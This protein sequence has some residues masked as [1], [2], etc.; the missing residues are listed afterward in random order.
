[1]ASRTA[2]GS[3]KT[4]FE[5]LLRGVRLQ[6]SIFFRPEFGAPWGVNISGHGTVF[7][8]VAG[9]T[10]WLRIKDVG[11]PIQLATGDFAVVTRGD[12]HVLSGDDPPTPSVDFFELIKRHGSGTNV[13]F[14]EGGQGPITSFVCGGMQFENGANDPLLAVLPPLLHIRGTENAAVPWLRLTVEQVLAELNYGGAG[15]A[16]VV[17]RL[18]DILFIQAVRTHFEDHADTARSGWLAAVRDKQIGRALALLHAH[19]DEPWTVEMLARRLTL[20]RSAFADRFREL[21]G[22]PPLQYLSRLRINAAARRLRSTNDKLS[23]V[24]ADAGY[25]SAAA[26]VRAFKQRVGMT[27]G[28]YR[29]SRRSGCW[30]S[31]SSG[32]ASSI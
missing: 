22:E 12:P 14:R 1:M 7:H 16:E 4:V 20:S 26:F 5:N 29:N 3:P 9:G 24:A 28:E 15:T 17:N 25:E 11:E 18:T 31:V 6:S 13:V 32:L 10:C 23:A 8:I 27:P 30:D 2:N 21:V 19:P